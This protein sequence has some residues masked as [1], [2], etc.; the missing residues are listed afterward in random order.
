MRCNLCPRRCNAP[1][2][3]QSGAGRCRMGTQ[4]VV[5]RAARHLW[6][7][8]CLSGT[9]GSGTV[10]FSG[11]AMGCAFCQNARISREAFGVRLSEREL[12]E[13]FERVE[14]LGVHNLNLVSPTHFAPAIL[15]AL[16]MRRMRIPVVWNSSG[17][18]RVEVVRACRGWVDVFLPDF[19]F[20]DSQTA[21]QV[22]QAP[23]YFPVALQAIRAMREQSGAAVYDAAGMLVS[24]TLVRHLVLPLR[25]EETR[26]I[27]S[28]VAQLPPTPVSLMR[29][30]T[31]MNGVSI[32]GLERRLTAREYARAREW[33]LQLGL[34]GYEQGA[35]AATD[36]FTP[37]FEDEESRLLL[38]GL[39][40]PV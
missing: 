37:D 1:R 26:R 7:E 29:Q 31:P 8:P 23:D 27:L 36:A 4:P 28:A 32:R 18:E 17:Y 22:A 10:F 9:R 24:G 38:E 34:E 2:G 40:T 3:A 15:R 13:L 33:M 19:K 16:Q 20:Y 25:V 5:A 14:A 12:C 35:Q 21:R 30:Y 11:C 39:G 6:E